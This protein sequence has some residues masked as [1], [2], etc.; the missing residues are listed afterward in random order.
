MEHRSLVV[1]MDLGEEYTQLCVKREGQ[2][3]ESI[4]IS[5][6]ND[7]FLIPTALCIRN[8]TKDWLFGEEAIR[9]RNREAG[10]FFSDLLGKA[11]RQETVT[12]YEME[13]T[14]AMLLERFVRKVLTALKQRYI[15]DTI[16][17][18]TVTVQELNE[19]LEAAIYQSLE[20]VGI[21]RDRAAVQNH[22][23][24][25][26]YYAVSQPKSLWAADVGLFDFRAEGMF[27]YQLSASRRVSPVAISAQTADLSDLMDYEM[28]R[29]MND[30]SLAYTFRT[31]TDK[32]LSHRLLSAIYVTGSGFEGAWCDSVLREL[33]VARRVFKGQ[34]LYVKGA[35]YAAAGGPAQNEFLFLT[36]D[37]LRATVCIRMFRDNRISD[38][39]LVTAGTKW[40]EVN[41]KTVGILDDT[42]EVFFT[43]LSAVRKETK[44]VVMN[45]RNLHRRENKTTR[46]SIGIRCIDRDTAVLTVKDLGFGQFYPN[47]Y[48]IWEKVIT[49]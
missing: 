7:R 18:V 23:L 36:E 33:C 14:G 17:R 19:N 29:S 28:L 46:V 32:V 15:Q 3:P 11:T 42:D 38:Y 10:C 6:G 45:L 39:P 21:R 47:T 20:G 16:E 4:C 22:L 13:F 9:C 48:R 24:S 41:A 1:G 34:N 44:H 26:M 27:Y 30:K 8:D 5:P 31:V 12:I 40:N 2:E 35:A 37:M 43:V 25:F 49:L